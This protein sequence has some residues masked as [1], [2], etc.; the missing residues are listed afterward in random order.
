MIDYSIAG[1]W[2][3]AVHAIAIIESGETPTPIGDGGRAFGL[4]QTHPALFAEYYGRLPHLFS[5][6]PSDTWPEAEIKCCATFFE[7][8]TAAGMLFDLIVQA[9]NE[10]V[11]AILDGQR[12]ETYLARFTTAYQRVR[13]GG[14]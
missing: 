8:N 9:W 3:D 7:V 11:Q 10:G 1:H 4:L 12:N 2:A 14:K 13:G 5:P 6:S